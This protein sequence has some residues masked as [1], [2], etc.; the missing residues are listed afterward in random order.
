MEIA[1]ASAACA[2]ATSESCICRNMARVRVFTLPDGF[3]Q[4]MNGLLSLV[5]III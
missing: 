5:N 3:V 4:V 1:F 2:V